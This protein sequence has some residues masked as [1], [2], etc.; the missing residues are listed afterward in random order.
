MVSKV[1]PTGQHQPVI[2]TSFPTP[3]LCRVKLKPPSDRAP[4]AAYPP[5]F[6]LAKSEANS[7]ELFPSRNKT[8]LPFI[9]EKKS[10]TDVVYHFS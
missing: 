3:P 8:R 4:Q 7:P 9:R 2:S 1:V 5:S 6:T 10:S